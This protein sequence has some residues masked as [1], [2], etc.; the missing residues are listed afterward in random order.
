ML[1]RF[2][3]F[4]T[5]KKIYYLG[6]L[7]SLVMI[8]C[9]KDESATPLVA[10]F[11]VNVTGESPNAQISITN[12]STGAKTYAWTFGEGASIETSTDE[13]PSS[14]TVD[15][16]GSLSVKL[17]VSNGNEEKEVTKT[18]SIA[19][20][21]AILSYVDIEFGLSAG[22]DTYGRLFSFDTGEIYK[23]SEIDAS[24]GSQMHLAFGSMSNTMYFFESP[25]VT[26]YNIPNATV[27]KVVNY[28]STPTISE[29]DF[30]GMSD[31]SNLAGLTINETN[32][33]FG[34]SSIPGTVLFEISTGRKGVIKTKQV[35]SDRI[36][37]DI[38]IQKY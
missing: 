1:N 33:S 5:M 11:S 13:V 16:A 24:N 2:K 31:D 17:V 9:S 34:N 37:V 25:A 10:D 30:D 21:S 12:S 14:I 6:I 20:N 7:A 19:G 18:I 28:E 3:K 32:D 15:K 36:L 35:N 23:D 29:A 27:T 26:E 22:S 38:K 8:S 4:K